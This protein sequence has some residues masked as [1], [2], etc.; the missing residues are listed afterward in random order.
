MWHIRDMVSGHGTDGLMVGL[1]LIRK[2]ACST[3]IKPHDEYILLSN[4]MCQS[5]DI[6]LLSKLTKERLSLKPPCSS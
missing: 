2:R 4:Q 1:D 6:P 3:I 5:A